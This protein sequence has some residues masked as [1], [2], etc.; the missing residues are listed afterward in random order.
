MPN[1]QD[2]RLPS[3]I[4]VEF[5]TPRT[6][7]RHV[8]PFSREFSVISNKRRQETSPEYK[9]VESHLVQ[10]CRSGNWREVVQRCSSNPEEA[11]PRLIEAGA[12][13]SNRYN[14]HPVKRVVNHEKQF[15]H[16]RDTLYHT[17]ALGIAC[18]SENI[19]V[20]VLND[21]VLALV[22]ASPSQ[23]CA[24]QRISGHTPLRDAILSPRCTP[25]ILKVL[26]DADSKCREGMHTKM[27]SALH[28]KDPNGLFPVDHLVIGVQLGS[29]PQPMN[30]IKTFFQ[31]TSKQS[32]FSSVHV[33]PLIRLL[34]TGTSFGIK[35]PTVGASPSS[36][37]STEDRSRMLRIIEVTK[38]FL[39]QDP[40]L[41]YQ[42]SNFTGCSPLHVALRNYGTCLPLIEELVSRDRR[43]SMV[44]LRN[45]YGDLPLHVASSVGV[46]MAVLKLIVYETRIA[47]TN[48]QNQNSYRSLVWSTNASG[49][50]PVDLEWVRHIESGLGLD[51]ARSFYPLEPTGM[52]KHYFKQ[53]DFYQEL[54]KEAVD[55]VMQTPKEWEERNSKQH[56]EEEAKNTFGLLIDR[57]S[58]LILAAT[59]APNEPEASNCLLHNVC[60]LSTPYGP[61][62]PLPLLELFLWVYREKLLQADRYGNLPLHHALQ[63][64][65]LLTNI[66]TLNLCEDWTNFILQLLKKAPESSKALN[67]HGRLPIHILLDRSCSDKEIERSRQQII[68]RLVPI[69]PEGIDCRDPLTKLFPFMMAAREPNLPIETIFF[70]LRRSPTRCSSIS[71]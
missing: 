68:K 1:R 67:E 12:Y 11:T 65:T 6:N 36:Y 62:L 15:T 2:D 47:A 28:K 24:S 7:R 32:N 5:E 37:G 59:E 43:K 45:H 4:P 19:E 38:Y 53:D 71:L 34:T 70:L 42:C 56:R 63:Q 21:V 61:S 13:V 50:T 25:Q 49:Y 30:L 35:R 64:G 44:K 31:F 29:S 16:D 3:W 69:Y 57:I 51:T 46:P 58:L 52:R 60:K 20:T 55:Q 39:E 33:S 26:L 66:P 54:L 17:T 40:E 41:L 10:L 27:K 8:A 22:K 23:V 48:N 9:Y 14:I 18:A